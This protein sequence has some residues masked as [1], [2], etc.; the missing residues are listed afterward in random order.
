[1]RFR[2]YTHYFMIVFMNLTIVYLHHHMETMSIPKF[3]ATCLAVLKRI[4]KTGKP[5]RI[6]RFGEPVA[7]LVPLTSGLKPKR[8]IGSMKSTGRIEG[9]IV[10]PALEPQEWEILRK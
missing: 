8:W 4:C 1:M 9:D 6:T 5:I 3:K 10:S 2:V 7:E